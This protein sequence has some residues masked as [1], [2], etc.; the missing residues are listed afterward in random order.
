M[1]AMACALARLSPEIQDYRATLF[2]TGER[3]FEMAQKCP[4]H[5]SFL[6]FADREVS[7]RHCRK[8]VG[9]SNTAKIR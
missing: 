9:A 2:L 5:G 6:Y 1:V 3:H 4:F 8:G 7:Q